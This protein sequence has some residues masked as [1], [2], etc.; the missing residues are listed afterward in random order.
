MGQ[1]SDPPPA[2]ETRGLTIHFGGQTVVD[3]V[4]CGFARGTLTAIVGPT[5]PARRRTSI[6]SRASCGRARG[7]VL[8]D[9]RDITRLTAPAR[10]R[11]GLG[12]AFQLTN[13]FP[14]LTVREN[15]RLA[16]QMRAGIGFDFLALA[17]RKTALIEAAQRLSRSGP[18]R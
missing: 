18:A 4:S 1:D 6:S 9:G 11:R 5:A 7:A 12:R 16:V 15:V 2:L 17:A 14:N 3:R 10:T 8:L 13:L